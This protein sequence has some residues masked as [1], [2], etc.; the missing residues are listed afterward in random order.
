MS[1]PS[2][3]RLAKVENSTPSLGIEAVDGPQDGEQRHLAQV[4]GG[5]TPRRSS[6]DEVLGYVAVVLD[7]AVPCLEILVV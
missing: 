1:S 2:I 4:V 3:V 7:E 5:D 6:A